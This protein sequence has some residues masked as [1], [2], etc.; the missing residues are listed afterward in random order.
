MGSRAAFHLMLQDLGYVETTNADA[1]HMKKLMRLANVVEARNQLQADGRDLCRNQECGEAATMQCGRCK[2][3]GIAVWYCGRDCQRKDYKGHK[4]ACKAGVVGKTPP[5]PT[6]AAPPG[7]FASSGLPPFLQSNDEPKSWCKGL[8]EKRAYK[9]FIDSYRLRIEDDYTMRGDASGLYGGEDPLPS[10]LRFL[11]K[12]RRKDLMPDWWNDEKEAALKKMALTDKWANIKYAVE[13]S[14]ITEH[15]G[16]GSGEHFILR[17]LAEQIEDGEDDESPY[18]E[19]DY[20]DDE[21]DDDELADY[22][23]NRYLELSK[24]A[25]FD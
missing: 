10:F 16:Y 6:F 4:E 18:E 22:A 11:R 25:G 2:E 3:N 17:G 1:D 15:Y 12:A 14:D 8:S 7:A 9:R 20:E 23:Y 19:S 21:S 5:A 13:K 24:K